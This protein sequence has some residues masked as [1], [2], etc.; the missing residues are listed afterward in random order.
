[1][2]LS[3]LGLA[4]PCLED[5]K[6][7]ETESLGCSAET[8]SQRLNK[9]ML[10]LVTFDRYEQYAQYHSPRGLRRWYQILMV[11]SLLQYFSTEGN[12]SPAKIVACAVNPCM[13]THVKSCQELAICKSNF[14]N[15]QVFNQFL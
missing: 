15:L 12:F 7:G 10:G 14:A 13:K 11:V 2:Q 8:W 3:K 9:S 6:W 4:G 5:S 1:M